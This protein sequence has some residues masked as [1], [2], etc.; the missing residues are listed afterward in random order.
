LEC[1][2]AK[3]E[4]ETDELL[5]V[6]SNLNCSG[7]AEKDLALRDRRVLGIS[8][9]DVEV[10]SAGYPV[11]SRGEIPL[12]WW[13]NRNLVIE[14]FVGNSQ[15]AWLRLYVLARRAVLWRTIDVNSI[16]KVTPWYPSET[17]SVSFD[18]ALDGCP[19]EYVSALTGCRQLS[20]RLGLDYGSFDIMYDDKGR[21]YVVDINATPYWGTL[22]NSTVPYLQ[23]G[24]LDMI[25]DGETGTE[26]QARN[27]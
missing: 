8:L 21:A 27:R 5:I 12:S 19:R 18:D 13:T 22:P 11:L 15:N 17:W 1:A 24:L 2:A 4:G 10:F 14:R 16:K 23:A 26:R 7:E 3:Q 20:S 9:E 6:K 25:R